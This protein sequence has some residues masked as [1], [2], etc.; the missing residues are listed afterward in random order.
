[1]SGSR[2]RSCF[3]PSE[4]PGLCDSCREQARSPIALPLAMA[5]A[6][7]R[8]LIGKTL[9]EPGGFGVTYLGWDASLERRIAIK[10]YFPQQLATRTAE[11]PTPNP[12]SAAAA[13][14]FSVGLAGFLDEARRL[15]KLDHP[16]IVKVLDYCEA[17]GTGYLV[18]NYYEG[19][20][21]REFLA[22]R[23]ARLDWRQALGL[24]LPLLD[25]L[26]E[27]HR[28][29]L[30]HRDIK[31]ANIYVASVADGSTRPILIDF[32]AARWASSTHE[33]TAVLTEGFAPLEQY[34]GCGP[35]G[36]FTDVYAVA[37][38]TY[39]IIV[40]ALPPS[41]PA[42]L[43][44]AVLPHLSEQM[45]GVP[46]SLG[47]AIVAG[48]AIMAEDRVQSAVELATQFRMALGAVTAEAGA[49]VLDASSMATKHIPPTRRAVP[50]AEPASAAGATR[51]SVRSVLLGVGVLVALIVVFLLTQQRGDRA[52]PGAN[53]ANGAPATSARPKIEPSKSSDGSSAGRGSV[54]PTRSV[55][56]LVASVSNHRAS[57]A[58]AIDAGEYPTA[59]RHALAIHTA[60]VAPEVPE[61]SQ[62]DW[63]RVSDSLATLIVTACGAE[64]DLVLKRGVS[65]PACPTRSW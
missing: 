10:E 46:R 11:N 4:Q 44:R 32:G 7:G 14:D 19:C 37:A 38:T 30:I 62:R 47:D 64:R 52:A 16:N 57:A 56:E 31:P 17:N 59:M 3:E 58:R 26:A 20:D 51:G 33:L 48:M 22:R 41:A 53:G 54:N 28:A 39:N 40:G 24:I 18:M 49:P 2:C 27:V 15:A 1:M 50:A 61:P 43:S 60:A 23:G 29:G 34:P 25:G 9:G 42:R 63:R 5:I 55:A 8:Y 45:P 35:Q 12:T 65:A 21:L 36:P 6:D 13:N